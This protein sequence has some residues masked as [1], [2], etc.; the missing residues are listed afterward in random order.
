MV[1][2]YALLSKRN[3]LCTHSLQMQ[4]LWW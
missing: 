1:A 2:F 4:Q 3:Y